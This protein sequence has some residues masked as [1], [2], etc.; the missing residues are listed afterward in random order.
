[1]DSLQPTDPA[2]AGHDIGFGFGFCWW[3][4]GVGDS[5]LGPFGMDISTTWWSCI[6][7]AIFP[8]HQ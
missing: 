2:E 6:F 8:R 7:S 3:A 1:M 5:T 4:V